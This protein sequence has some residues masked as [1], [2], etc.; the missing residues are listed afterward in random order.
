MEKNGDRSGAV[1]LLR[2][3]LTDP[4]DTLR[5]H[6]AMAAGLLEMPECLPVLRTLAEMAPFDLP[7]G[8]PYSCLK[9]RAIYRLGRMHDRE[10][11][12]ILR[13]VAED[14]VFPE[15]LE[16]IPHFAHLAIE[17]IESGG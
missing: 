7:H 10:A 16:K 17:R 4:D 9:T 8:Y 5:Y 3:W 6:A 13:R 1:L 12:P 11:L 15:N 14:E 2:K